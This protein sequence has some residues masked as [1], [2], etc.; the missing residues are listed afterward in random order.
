MAGHTTLRVSACQQRP[1]FGG[2]RKAAR[3][4]ASLRARSMPAK[5][6]PPCG[7][8]CHRPRPLWGCEFCRRNLPRRVAKGWRWPPSGGGRRARA[9]AALRDGDTFRRSLASVLFSPRLRPRLRWARYVE[10]GGLWPE[11]AGRLAPLL[12]VQ[13]IAS[14]VR[15]V[16]AP[17]AVARPAPSCLQRSPLGGDRATCGRRDG[18]VP[19]APPQLPHLRR[20]HGRGPPFLVR[21]QAHPMRTALRSAP[22]AG[23]VRLAWMTIGA[24]VAR[25]TTTTK[26]TARVTTT[27]RPPC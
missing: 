27:S 24:R 13:G 26:P 8:I 21:A 19:Q 25:S 10:R 14:A 17:A 15:M 2:R 23:Q 1:P 18:P 20:R 16:R 5:S 3:E 4:A 9:R 7:Y 12:G 11:G 22:L 6:R